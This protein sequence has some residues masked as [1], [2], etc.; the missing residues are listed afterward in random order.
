MNSLTYDMVSQPTRDEFRE[1]FYTTLGQRAWP[2]PWLSDLGSIY[3]Y[4]YVMNNDT[5]APHRAS[6]RALTMP[7][8]RRCRKPVGHT[9]SNFAMKSVSG[10]EDEA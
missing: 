2:D 1:W 7:S 4:K 10:A 5:R 6:K 3:I 9:S 8:Q